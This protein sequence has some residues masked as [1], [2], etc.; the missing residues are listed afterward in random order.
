MAA[1]PST[2][3]YPVKL[4]DEYDTLQPATAS[5]RG[6]TALQAREFDMAGP[7][8]NLKEQV[9]SSHNGQTGADAATTETGATHDKHMGEGVAGAAGA[10]AVG[11]G[12]AVA[13][14]E[15]VQ[16]RDSVDKN[17]LPPTASSA[18]ETAAV[19]ADTPAAPRTEWILKVWQKG[20]HSSGQDVVM[21][22]NGSTVLYTIT[23]PRTGNG[24]SL[25]KGDSTRD[26]GA[27]ELCTVT[28]LANKDA[29]IAFPTGWKTELA[30]S[31]LYERK[32][33]FQGFDGQEFAWAGGSTVGLDLKCVQQTSNITVATYKRG[34]YTSEKEATLTINIA[35]ESQLDLFVATAIAQERYEEA[36]H[37]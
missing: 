34:I 5:S 21:S 37:S 29:E 19:A 11:A 33:V 12:T 23:T 2:T 30:K 3:E 8:S 14:E 7:P 36:L 18:P 16:S 32:H 13:A 17:E 35:L 15:T 31:G 4:S 6:M 20:S 24:F 26:S 27:S 22:E 10:G 25:I 28:T 1:G 9:R